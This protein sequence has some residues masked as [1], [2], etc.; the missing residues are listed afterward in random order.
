MAKTLQELGYEV[1]STGG[2]QRPYKRREYLQKPLKKSRTFRNAGWTC[3]DIAPHGTWRGLCIAEIWKRMQNT[4]K[5]HDIAPID[6]VVVN[7][8]AF[9]QSL[10]VNLMKT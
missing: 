7:L 1:I 3:K 6:V 5:E 10:K 2:T 8:Y 4:A 9:E